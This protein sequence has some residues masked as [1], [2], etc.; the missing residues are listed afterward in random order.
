MKLSSIVSGKKAFLFDFD[1]VVTDSETYAFMT[2]KT[3]MKKYYDVDVD[4]GDIAL[5]IGMDAFG[6]AAEV[7]RKYGVDMPGERFI[8]LV[9]T[10]PDYYTEYPGIKPFPSIPEL[11][12][13]LKERGIRIA[14]VSST[15]TAH[16]HAA[17]GRMGLESYPEAVIGG[18]S[19]SRHK[20]DPEPY[21]AGMKA[22]GCTPDESVAIED[23]PVGLLSARRAGVSTIGFKGSV[24]EQDTSLADIAISDYQ[25]LIAALCE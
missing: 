20:P 24:V 22:L 18:D 7:S 23:S 13:M 17:L 10:I 9:R 12:S 21:L 15:R 8:E 5:T 2:L 19:V 25:E 16:L 6:T 11:F 3:V 1:G 14:I 4:D